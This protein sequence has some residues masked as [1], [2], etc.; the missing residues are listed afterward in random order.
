MSA[1]DLSEDVQLFLRDRIR[2][3]EQLEALRLIHSER[4]E[5]WTPEAIAARLRI[6]PAVADEALQRLYAQG[7]L[8]SRVQAGITVYRYA[9]DAQLDA[10][11]ANI[12]KAYD[13]N[14]VAVMTVMTKNAVE[15][16]RGS[17]INTFA[18]AFLIGRKRDG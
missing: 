14:R 3:F 6:P 10:G 12:F 7:L 1:E 13:E 2:S 11:V 15:R 4:T 5:A 16:V 8:S 9:A 17:V 18:D